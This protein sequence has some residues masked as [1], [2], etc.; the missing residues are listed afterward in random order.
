MKTSQAFIVK[1]T[2]Y[3]TSG[4]INNYAFMINNTQTRVKLYNCKIIHSF[5]TLY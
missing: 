1:A 2:Y 3:Y 4:S 5:Y